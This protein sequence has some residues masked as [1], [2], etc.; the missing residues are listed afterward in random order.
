MVIPASRSELFA[1]VGSL[2]E[3]IHQKVRLGIMSALMARA[4]A[5]FRF[6]KETLNVTDGNLSIHLTKLEE[7]GYIESRKEFVRKK[8]HTTYSPTDRGREAFSGYLAAL[9]RIVQAAGQQV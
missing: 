4:E 6:L 7:A 2:D 8:P 1:S 3:V 5:D 9:E